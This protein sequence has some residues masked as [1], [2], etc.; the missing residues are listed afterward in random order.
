MDV[1]RHFRDLIVYE[2]KV[3]AYSKLCG[4]RAVL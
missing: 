1:T 3:A 4:C 2:L